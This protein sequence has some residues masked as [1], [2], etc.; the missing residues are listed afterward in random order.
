MNMNKAAT[1]LNLFC[2]YMTC[3]LSLALFI[4]LFSIPLEFTQFIIYSISLFGLIEVV[5]RI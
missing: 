1:I 5:K 3:V 2:D 4:F